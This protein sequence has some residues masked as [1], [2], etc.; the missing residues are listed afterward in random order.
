MKIAFYGTKP[1]DKIW[2][3]PL[4]KNTDLKFVL[5]SYRVGRDDFFGKRL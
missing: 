3:E 4:A 2:F 5:L 1:Y